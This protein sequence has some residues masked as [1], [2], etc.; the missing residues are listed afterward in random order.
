MRSSLEA[1][2]NSVGRKIILSRRPGVAGRVLRPPGLRLFLAAALS[3]S[4]RLGSRFL[5]A[6]THFTFNELVLCAFLSSKILLS[7]SNTFI[8]TPRSSHG[9][10]TVTVLEL[11]T[12]ESPLLALTTSRGTTNV[13]V[14]LNL[15]HQQQHSII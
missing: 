4:P 2:I 1:N 7:I 12:S 6:T 5:F 9:H 3:S 11:I 13:L 14:E 10:Q 8:S 15:Y